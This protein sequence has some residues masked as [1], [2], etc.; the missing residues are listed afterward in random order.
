MFT[1]NGWLIVAA[2]IVGLVLIG[3]ANE[4]EGTQTASRDDIISIPGV[5]QEYD[6]NVAIKSPAGR[7]MTED[8]RLGDPEAKDL[9][10][11]GSIY[12]SCTLDL[13]QSW[14]VLYEQ[15]PTLVRSP[16]PTAAD[17]VVSELGRSYSDYY[18]VTGFYS[19][20][21]REVSTNGE[22]QAKEMLAQRISEECA[23]R[24]AQ[25]LPSYTGE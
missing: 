3:I 24:G 22:T 13:L 19:Q 21:G 4:N 8:L 6:L 10:R 15:Y 1:K 23:F 9:L 18:F 12:W 5:D 14:S 2:A 25:E 7:Y 11:P 17:Y 16:D 20:Y